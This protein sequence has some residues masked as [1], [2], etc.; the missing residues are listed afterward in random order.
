M[1]DDDGRQPIAKN[2]EQWFG[3]GLQCRTEVPQSGA[4]DSPLRG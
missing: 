4:M 3:G 1:T 2:I